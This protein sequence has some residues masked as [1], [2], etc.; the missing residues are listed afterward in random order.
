[1]NKEKRKKKR[2]V[3]YDELKIFYSEWKKLESGIGI[4]HEERETLNGQ[5]MRVKV[6]L[7]YYIFVTVCINQGYIF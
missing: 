1:M 7:D 3:W 5:Q 6:L 2:T 4:G